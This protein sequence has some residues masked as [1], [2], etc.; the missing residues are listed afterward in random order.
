[1]ELNKVQ[2]SYRFIFYHFITISFLFFFLPLKPVIA[3][4]LVIVTAKDNLA[5]ITID[6]V[7]RIFLGK[8]NKYPNGEDVIPLDINPDDPNYDNFVR[9]VLKRTPS[10]LRAYWAKRIFTGKGTPPK[11]ISTTEELLDLVSK[12]KRYLSYIDSEDMKHG[13]RWVIV[14][15]NDNY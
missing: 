1:M 9:V 2:S 15:K 7:A 11:V 3:D 14:I 12:D 6:D 8:I 13:V 10:Q 4:G 5:D